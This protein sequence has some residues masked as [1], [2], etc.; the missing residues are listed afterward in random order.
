MPRNDLAGKKFGRLT[1]LNFSDSI[2]WR[3]RWLC[4]C[5]CGKEK[6]VAAR[7]L[8]SKSIISCGC[9]KTEQ[10]IKN[11]TTHGFS[12]SKTYE[13]WSKM[14]ARCKNLK[15]NR[16]LRYGGRG[17]IVCEE[18]NSFEAFLLDMGERPI[19]KTIDRIDNN[20]NYCKENCKWSTP[21]EQCTNRLQRKSKKN[22]CHEV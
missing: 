10:L 19:G 4:L 1:V 9:F 2:N 7:H 15:N 5:E 12:R 21:K 13:S 11:K 3:P 6:I 16:F 14:H 20:G 17:I 8:T 18:W 22:M